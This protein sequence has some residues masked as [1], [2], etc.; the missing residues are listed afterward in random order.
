MKLAFVTPWYGPG[1]PG[2][3]E[4]EAR[5]TIEKLHQSGVSIEVLT[6]TI[7]DFHAD[8]G[9]NAH[10]P[11]VYQID[12][13]TV[14][15]FSVQKRD[16][17]AFDAVNWRLMQDLPITK[18]EEQIYIN[19]MIRTP[20]LYDYITQH[21]SDRLFIFIP[22]MFATTYHGAKICPER[23]LMIPCLHDESYARLSIYQEVIPKVKGLVL[24]VDAELELTQRLFGPANGQMRMVVGVGVD[25]DFEADA[26]R[27][28]QKY[29]LKKPFMLYA[30]RRESGKNTP[31]L[32]DYWQRYKLKSDNDVVLVLVGSGSVEI[33]PSAQS[34]ILDLG[35]VSSQDKYDA[36]AAAS[37]F[38]MPSVNESFSIV[39][40]ESWLAGTPVL[41]NGQ[42]AVTKEHCQR[43]NGGLY[44]SN[45]E[46]FAATV[47]YMME[48]PV[49][50]EQ[51]GQNGRQYVLD[52]YQWP[53]IIEKYRQMIDLITEGDDFG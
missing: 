14:H 50:A 6:T 49:I 53:T 3:A 9:H 12:G 5:L 29:N 40:M 35:F 17:S 51:M 10:K 18:E 22:Y 1:I 26:D 48:N 42:C 52:N 46:E 34:H 37:V 16:K 13:I 24:N 30:G 25:T 15:R 33:P 27:F 38:C 44:F 43:N 21:K 20:A 47:D 8:W 4:A 36:F 11:G 2:G 19:E 41:V 45:Y 32:I 28:R 7:K 31:L 23:S 39:I